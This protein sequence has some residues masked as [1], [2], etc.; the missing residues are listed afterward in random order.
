M[1][2]KERSNPKKVPLS[3]DL[4]RAPSC[5]RLPEVAVQIRKNLLIILQMKTKNEEELRAMG[6][7]KSKIRI[8][9]FPP[10]RMPAAQGKNGRLHKTLDTSQEKSATP[11]LRPTLRSPIL[12]TVPL[13]F[14]CARS[15]P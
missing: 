6:K 7:W 15:V 5:T 13:P 4:G 11:R 10:P 3:Q 2:R 9:T 12:R 1:S 14:P 8:P